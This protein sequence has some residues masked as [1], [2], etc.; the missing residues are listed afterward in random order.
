M[1]PR[2]PRKGCKWLSY[3]IQ[4]MNL[5][6]HLFYILLFFFAWRGD[7]NRMDITNVKLK[8][9]ICS[10]YR[11]MFILIKYR[12]KR[13]QVQSAKILLLPPKYKIV[14]V[15]SNHSNFQYCVSNNELF[16]IV[17][18]KVITHN[19]LCILFGISSLLIFWWFYF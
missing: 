5:K 1:L 2:G 6:R 11:K 14:M 17:P 19:P 4:I 3:V 18:C 10:Q 16:S 13:N 12:R 8:L 7:T 9:T 15:P